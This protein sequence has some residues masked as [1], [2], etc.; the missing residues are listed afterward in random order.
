MGTHESFSSNLLPNLDGEGLLASDVFSTH[1]YSLSV[2]VLIQLLD[3]GV[4]HIQSCGSL[5]VLF[6]DLICLSATP[7]AQHRQYK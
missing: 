4:L 3:P 6:S 2:V 7:G 1:E 5:T